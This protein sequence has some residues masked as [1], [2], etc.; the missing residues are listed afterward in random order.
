MNTILGIGGLPELCAPL[1]DPTPQ[2][3]DGELLCTGD[4]ALC[5]ITSGGTTRISSQSSSLSSAKKIRESEV[6]T[7]SPFCL[8]P[9]ADDDEERRMGNSE[10]LGSSLFSTRKRSSLAEA[11]NA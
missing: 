8:K 10:G 7:R 5:C 11:A 1:S 3:G 2:V 4:L 9:M 6:Y